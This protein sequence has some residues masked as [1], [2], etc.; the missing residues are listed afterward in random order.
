MATITPHQPTIA[1]HIPQSKQEQHE[2]PS[3]FQG[4]GGPQGMLDVGRGP[5]LQLFF[6]R[7]QETE[8]FNAG[9][10]GYNPHLL[11]GLV[12]LSQS[13]VKIGQGLHTKMVFL[14][15]NSLKVPLQSV[16][17]TETSTSKVNITSANDTSTSSDLNGKAVP[18]AC[19][20]LNE[21]LQPYRNPVPSHHTMFFHLFASRTDGNLPPYNLFVLRRKS[22]Q[23]RT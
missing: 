23:F 14:F 8:Q 2:I 4:F 1:Q 3:T 18:D 10:R 7:V 16:Y 11:N 17:V 22:G 12:L 20:Q 19:H 6:L 9:M 13:G 5:Q 21:R 15:A